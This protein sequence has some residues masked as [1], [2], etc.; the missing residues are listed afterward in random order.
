MIKT[1][2]IY[3]EIILI[4]KKHGAKKISVFGSYAREEQTPDSDID[5]IAEFSDGISLLELVGIE[6]ELNEAIGKNV[7]LLTENAISL[8][9]IDS[10]KQ[11][12]RVIYH[13]ER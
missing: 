1:K 4:L 5:I 12:M 7:D 8:Y 11:E 6:Q 10:I 9:L 13:G 3:D 2:Q